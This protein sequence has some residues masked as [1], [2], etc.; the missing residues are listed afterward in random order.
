M[1][2][3]SGERYFAGIDYTRSGTDIVF[4]QTPWVWRLIYIQYFEQ[5]SISQVGETNTMMNIPW[6]WFGVYKQKTGVQ[7]EMRRITGINGITV[8][9][10]GDEIVI[11][12]MVQIWP[13]WEINSWSNVWSWYWLYK[14]KNWVILQFKT[15]TLTPTININE[16]IDWDSLELSVN[17]NWLSKNYYRHRMF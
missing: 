6:P 9:Q 15:L 4:L 13:G 12:W 14:W 16:S 10:I 1:Y 7:F 8:S 11:D 3:D 17:E 5:I 2:N